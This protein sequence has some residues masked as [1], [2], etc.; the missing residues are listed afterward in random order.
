METTGL[1]HSEPRPAEYEAAI[2]IAPHLKKMK[3]DIMVKAVSAGSRGLIPDEVDGLINTVRRR[4]TDLWIEGFLKPTESTRPNRRGRS[5]TVWVV[6]KDDRRFGAK[7]AKDEKIAR[8]ES[9]V[10]ELEAQ[11]A[12]IPDSK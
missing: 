11:A 7:E 8:L 2:L 10:R 9:R 3:R 6:G 5:E 12:A 4:F 1:H